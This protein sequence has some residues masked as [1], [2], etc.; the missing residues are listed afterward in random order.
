MG[1]YNI[2]F[3]RVGCVWLVVWARFWVVV[4]YTDWFGCDALFDMLVLVLIVMLVLVFCGGLVV[5]SGFSAVLGFWVD[6]FGWLPVG[7][8]FVWGWC[9]ILFL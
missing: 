1:L 4:A 3:L 9:N 7:F 5:G 2:S 8:S 6:W